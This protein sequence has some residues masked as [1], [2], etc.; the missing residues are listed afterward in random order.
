MLSEIHSFWGSV[1]NLWCSSSFPIVFSDTCFSGKVQEFS[2]SWNF[3]TNFHV[4]LSELVLRSGDAVW[5]AINRLQ[6][7]E[8]SLGVSI[9]INRITLHTRSNVLACFTLAAAGD[10]HHLEL[11]S[12]KVVC[13]GSQFLAHQQQPVFET[14]LFAIREYRE[15]RDLG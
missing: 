6:V 10:V 15:I 4:Q 2:K 11:G 14:G 1:V 8:H 3:V 5:I 12:V 9:W 7:V 13:I